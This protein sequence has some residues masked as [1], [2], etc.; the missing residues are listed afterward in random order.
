MDITTL[1]GFAALAGMV[2]LGVWTGQLP[3]F[4]LNW[5]GLGI[6]LG[7]TFSAML[8]NTPLRDVGEAFGAVIKL[9]RGSRY[10]TFPL[11]AAQVTSLAESV[12]ARGRSAL[13][14]ADTLAVGGYLGRAAAVAVEYNNPEIVMQI[15]EHEIN[16]DF[17]HQ[18]E[19]VNVFRTMSVLAP[20][21]GLLGTLIGIVSV[22]REI[23]NPENVGKSMA[24]AMTTAFYGIAMANAFCVPIAGKLRSRNIQELRARSMVADGV[25]MMLRGTIPA[26]IERK[27]RSYR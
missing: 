26:I 25:V 13:Q 27:L 6:V 18:N 23:S 20:M 24:V 4:F 11:I 5:H 1:A 10:P 12:H 8:V 3:S 22:L 15:L 2:L 7:G 19:M 9:L 16:M 17:D 21:F 14:E